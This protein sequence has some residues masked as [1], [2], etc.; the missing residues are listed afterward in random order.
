MVTH[1]NN[2][3]DQPHICPWY[4]RPVIVIS[5]DAPNLNPTALGGVCTNCTEQKPCCEFDTE[6]QSTA[7]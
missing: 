4:R 2:N 5:L 1:R 6:G 7:S 3:I